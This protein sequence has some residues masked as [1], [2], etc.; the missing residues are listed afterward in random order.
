MGT[1]KIYIC[2]C[3]CARAHA[4]LLSCIQ[5]CDPMDCSPPGSS[6]HGISQARKLEWVAIPSPGD[7]P[8]PGIEPG[9]PALQADSLPSEP[10]GIYVCVCVCVFIEFVIVLDL[11]YALI[12][13]A[14][15][16]V[17]S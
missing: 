5:L 1:Q 13:L 11:F 12:F 10:P 2:V 14:T 6:V 16:H 7:L 8:D 9:S 17:G 4:Q 3:V 15:K